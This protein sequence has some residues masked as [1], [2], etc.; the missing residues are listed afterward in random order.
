ME[1]KLNL[2]EEAERWS[3]ELGQ[4]CECSWREDGSQEKAEANF[5]DAMLAFAKVV[6][7]GV[8]FP[9]QLEAAADGLAHIDGYEEAAGALRDTAARQRDLVEQVNG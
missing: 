3:R 7:E 5:K 4:L 2:K 6:L 1:P 9:W 8:C